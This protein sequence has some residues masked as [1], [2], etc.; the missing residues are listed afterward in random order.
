MT[1]SFA[2]LRFLYMTRMNRPRAYVVIFILALF[3]ARPT[4]VGRGGQAAQDYL[5]YVV[6]E[7][8]DKIALIRFGQKTPS[9]PLRVKLLQV[10]ACCTLIPQCQLMVCTVRFDTRTRISERCRHQP[11]TSRPPPIQAGTTP[12]RFTRQ[13]MFQWHQELLPQTQYRTFIYR[14]CGHPQ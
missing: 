3:V 5:V 1:S 11:I 2:Q 14:P 8:A 9:A 6:C 12:G 7:S 4:A 10:S 13:S